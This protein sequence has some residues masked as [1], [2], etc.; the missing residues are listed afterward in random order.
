MKFRVERDVLAEAVSW[1]ARSLSPRPPVPVL[2]GLLLK[3]EHGTVSLSSFDYETSA[4]LEIPAEIRDEGTILVSGR[5][6]ADICRSLPSAPVDIETDGSKVTLTCRRSSFH[7]ATMPENEYPAL[8]ALP[9]S[10]G[11]VDGAA[12]SQA[13]SQVIIAASKDDTLPILTGVR[14]EFEDDLITFLA[15]DRYRLAMKELPWAPSAP[16]QSMSALVKAKTL[17]EVAKTLGGSGELKLAITQDDSRLIAFES[18]GR[19]TTS[20]LVDGDYPKIRSLFP[21]TT[22]IHAVVNTSELVEAVRRVSLVAERNTPVRLAFTDGQVHL[23]AGTGEDAQASE[24][25]EARLEGEDITVA[26][27]PGYLIEGLSVI[28]TRFVRFSFTSAPKPAMLTA[29]AELEGEDSDDYRYLVMP[30]RLPN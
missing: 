23:D 20:L 27:N 5:L 18:A 2:S 6:L 12:F 15:T 9:D 3:A 29:Q 25:L 14:L 30:V 16:G 22:A 1:A 24:E 11:M 13:V 28:E 17:N 10:N 26:F 19:A 4:R 8:P 21:E 7:L